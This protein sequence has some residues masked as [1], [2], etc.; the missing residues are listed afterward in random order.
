MER[1]IRARRTVR[2]GRLRGLV[3]LLDTGGELEVAGGQPTLGMAGQGQ[4]DLVPADVDVR[5][6]ASRLGRCGDIV[7]EHHRVSEVLAPEGLDDLVAASLPAGETLQA[8][9]D[10]GVVQPWHCASFRANV[11]VCHRRHRW[12]QQLGEPPATQRADYHRSDTMG[13]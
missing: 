11:I 1:S 10:S 2:L 13:I 3:E 9:L 6:V 4:S 7:D 12:E 8:L 5:M